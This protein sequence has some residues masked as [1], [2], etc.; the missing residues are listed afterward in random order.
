[1]IL[2]CYFFIQILY[3]PHSSERYKIQLKYIA[4]KSNTKQK[5]KQEQQI[6]IAIMRASQIQINY[7]QSAKNKFF[8]R[9]AQ[10]TGKQYSLYL[11]SKRTQS[12][13]QEGGP[14]ERVSQREGP[15]PSSTTSPHLNSQEH[16]E[17]TSYDDH[18][19]WAGSQWTPLR[20]SDTQRP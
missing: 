14:R 10:S 4:L 6:A 5:S 8:K 12:Q 20:V 16:L 19:K 2:V 7:W 18:I 11:V 1:M 9:T 15:V 3:Q 13:C 17:R